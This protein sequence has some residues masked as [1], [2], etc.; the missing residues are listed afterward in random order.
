MAR[1]KSSGLGVFLLAFALVA[2]P[3][4]YK[5]AGENKE[6]IILGISVIGI[7][8]LFKILNARR[9][10]ASWMRYIREK[11][12]DDEYIVSGILAGKY[13]KD[14]TEEQL[15]DSLG[16]PSRVDTQMLKTKTKEIW[17]YSEQRKGQFALK[18]TIEN[19]KVVGW[20]KKS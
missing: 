12:D 1:K 10:N 11:Y 14:Q 9:R 20:D 16:R 17:K 18:I 8:V 2:I 6:I 7:F 4:A 3:A 19:G 15:K 13:W 5:W